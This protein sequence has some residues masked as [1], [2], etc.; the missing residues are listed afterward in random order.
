METDT[1][2]R[3]INIRLKKA[4]PEK[5]PESL[6]EPV[7]KPIFLK[8]SRPG[9]RPQL[10][11]EF[12]NLQRGMEPEFTFQ[13]FLFEL[14]HRGDTFAIGESVYEV[15]SVTRNLVAMDQEKVREAITSVLVAR[16]E[17][18]QDEPR[19]RGQFAAT[20]QYQERYPQ[21]RRP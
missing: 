19:P 7:S 1:T 16:V 4:Q 21:G 6:K 9:I 12:F 14:P 15:K 17:P 5:A 8:D 13:A 20:R 2:L 3:D 18:Y 11:V 10:K